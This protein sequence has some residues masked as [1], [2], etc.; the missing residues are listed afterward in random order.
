[1]SQI[2]ANPNTLTSIRAYQNP[3]KTWKKNTQIPKMVQPPDRSQQNLSKRPH[4]PKK[5]TFGCGCGQNQLAM[6][7]CQPPLS[8]CVWACCL[9]SKMFFSIGNQWQALTGS[10]IQRINTSKEYIIWTFQYNNITYMYVYSML[11]IENT[12]KHPQMCLQRCFWIPGW[13]FQWLFPKISTLEG[14]EAG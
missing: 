14:P 5:N 1:M 7:I 8:F 9:G 11:I 10:S 2:K 3:I 13:L 12:I 4:K 6:C